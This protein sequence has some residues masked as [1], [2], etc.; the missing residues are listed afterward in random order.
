[1]ARLK[2]LGQALMVGA[3][4]PIMWVRDYFRNNNLDEWGLK[5][6]VGVTL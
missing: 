6:V 5:K 4:I 2:V 3:N 1:M